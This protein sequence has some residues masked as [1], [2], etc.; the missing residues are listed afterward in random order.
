MQSDPPRE[1]A[2]AGT[3]GRRKNETPVPAAARTAEST[4]R[5]RLGDNTVKSRLP[6]TYRQLPGGASGL[7][8]ENP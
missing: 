7:F 8:W 1:A 4:I 3:Q 2:K 6:R 5:I